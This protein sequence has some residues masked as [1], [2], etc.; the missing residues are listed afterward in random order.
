[1]K[2]QYYFVRNIY[3]KGEIQLVYIFTKKQITDSLTK[4]ID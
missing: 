4:S 2:I 1:M 3:I